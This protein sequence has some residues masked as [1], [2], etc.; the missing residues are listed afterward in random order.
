MK[1]GLYRHTY[2]NNPHRNPQQCQKWAMQ[3]RIISILQVWR[4]MCSSKFKK[5]W[6]MS[7]YFV[8]NLFLSN[9]NARKRFIKST[10]EGFPQKSSVPAEQT[11]GRKWH[12]FGGLKIFLPSGTIVK[13]VPRLN[14]CKWN[15][16]RR[17]CATYKVNWCQKCFMWVG[18]TKSCRSVQLA[19]TPNPAG[20]VHYSGRMFWP[21]ENIAFS[22]NLFANHP[23]W[24]QPKVW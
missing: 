14:E 6:K 21:T 23:L 13:L 2:G 3:T 19:P 22:A 20:Q 17:Y 16:R 4:W 24:H 12:P 8:S 15:E 9:K 5:N 7:Y 1:S 11:G 18:F 10:F